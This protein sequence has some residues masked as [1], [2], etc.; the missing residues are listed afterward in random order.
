MA[1]DV[2]V[3]DVIPDGMS[4]VSFAEGLPMGQVDGQDLLWALGN[5][6]PGVYTLG[7]LARTADFLEDGLVLH[8]VVYANHLNDPTPVTGYADVVIAANF[9]I[10]VGVYNSAGEM[11]KEILVKDFSQPIDS[12]EVLKDDVISSLND[13]ADL[14]YKGY[15]VGTWDGTDSSGKPVGNG[16]YTVKIDNIDEFGMTQTLTEQVT[17]YRSLSEVA[18]TVYDGSGEA[19]RHLY[20]LVEDPS[21]LVTN[22]FVSEEM[23]SPNYW[24]TQPGVVSETAV[25]LSTGVQVVWDGRS[26]SGAIVANGQYYIEVR[27]RDGSG[28]EIVVVKEVAVL[29][30]PTAYEK[31]VVAPNVLKGDL[32]VA[33]V[34]TQNPLVLKATVYN[35]AGE[36]VAVVRSAGATGQVSW[37]AQGAANGL[38]LLA[39]ELYD[40]QGRLLGRQTSKLINLTH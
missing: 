35:V 27:S 14:F 40:S 34:R 29:G 11:V 9:T 37:D 18:I 33:T 6:D 31:A 19:V 4:F 8:N 17:V 24:G 10:R 21:S 12:V 39:I 36:K 16:E 25:V 28:G 2:T 22:V 1:H 26:D 7:Y 5:L 32:K 3:R 38:Y 13:R 30:N 15:L 20:A 23:I